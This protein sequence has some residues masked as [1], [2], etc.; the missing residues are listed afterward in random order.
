MKSLTTALALICL[1]GAADA[2]AQ[3]AEGLAAAEEAFVNLEYEAAS[4][5]AQQALESGGN[6]PSDTQRLYELIG[7]S[8]SFLEDDSRAYD[9]YLRMLAL[10]PDAEM[11]RSLPPTMRTPFL[12]ARGW[13]SA[14]NERFS[15]SVEVADPGAPQPVRIALE[16]H[17]PLQLA[18]SVRLRVRPAGAETYEDRDLQSG[19]RRLMSSVPLEVGADVREVDYILEVRDAQSN[20]LVQRGTEM[21]PQRIENPRYEPPVLGGSVQGGSEVWEEW[22]FWS[23]IGGVVAGAALGVG[24]Y[25]G[26]PPQLNGQ[27]QVVFGL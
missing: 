7:L 23:L 6:S 19:E 27:T 2:A 11:D 14:Q 13:W 20:V 10:N 22:W 26:L 5:A 17:D 4:E 16:M 18:A 24:L 9:A 12:R 15:V 21:D 3:T 25:F 1:L 8:A